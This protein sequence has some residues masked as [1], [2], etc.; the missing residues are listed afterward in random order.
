[1]KILIVTSPRVGGTNF[2]MDLAK[3][4]SLPFIN[5]PWESWGW[6]RKTQD[7]RNYISAILSTDNYIIHSHAKDVR[8][9]QSFDKVINLQ[10]RNIK[11]QV[12]S[13]LVAVNTRK[14]Q[15][16]MHDNLEFECD[17][18]TIKELL[19]EIY[20]QQKTFD[21]ISYPVYYEDLTIKTG[22]KVRYNNVKILNFEE[23]F[24][25]VEHIIQ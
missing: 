16:C 6:S 12:Y 18:R 15:N 20:Y 25:L 4:Y 1:M 22:S 11:E 10:R 9:L 13:Y 17:I 24:K 5:E 21:T 3:Q 2:A 19:L 23:C 8:N 7:E 14:F